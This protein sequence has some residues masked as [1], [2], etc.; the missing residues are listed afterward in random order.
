M[1]GLDRLPDFAVGSSVRPGLAKLVEETGELGEMAGKVM[2]FP[3]EPHPSGRDVIAEFVTEAG[4]V[5][6][7]LRYIASANADI[8][9]G[10]IERAA[11]RRLQTL[12]EWHIKER[13]AHGRDR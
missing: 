9:V 3:H 1:S 8:S 6:G 11:E 7:T 12:L 10:D 13:S 2:A 4:D 5:L